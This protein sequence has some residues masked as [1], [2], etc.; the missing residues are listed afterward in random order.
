M[1]GAIGTAA[2]L[3]MAA[4]AAITMAGITP[5]IMVGTTAG[6]AAM[7]GAT[8]GA[9]AVD[10]A[11]VMA[12]AGKPADTDRGGNSRSGALP[13]SREI[14]AL[15]QSIRLIEFAPALAFALSC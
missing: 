5:G 7:A 3:T 15:P 6:T 4:G 14:Q 11:G 1:V 13:L 10:A 12:G 2:A 8:A 9:V